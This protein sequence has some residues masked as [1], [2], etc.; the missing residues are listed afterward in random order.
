MTMKLTD[1]TMHAALA[2]LDKKEFSAVELTEAYI[3]AVEKI[4]PLNAF[5]TETP[6]LARE[7]AWIDGGNAHWSKRPLLHKRRAHHGR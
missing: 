7:Q 5:I 6:E 4:R 3:K 2:G 1:L